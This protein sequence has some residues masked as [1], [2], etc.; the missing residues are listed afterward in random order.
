[1][2]LFRVTFLALTGLLASMTEG[3]A[4]A[5]TTFHVHGN[6]RNRSSGSALFVGPDHLE[7]IQSLVTTTTTSSSSLESSDLITSLLTGEKLGELGKSIVIV[8]LF[9]GG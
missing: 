1:M 7:S 9:G 2:V 6:H 5:P 3:F 8:L 4:P